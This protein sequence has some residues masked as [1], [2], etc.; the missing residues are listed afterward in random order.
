MKNYD[1]NIIEKKWQTIWTKQNAFKSKEKYN[2]KKYYCLVMLPY[3]SG[4]LHMG[5]V[6]NYTIGDVL[7]RFH[8]MNGENVLHPMGWD[9]FGLPAENAAIANN[10]HPEIW[11]KKNIS[12]MKKQLITLG[13]SYDWD[14]EITTCTPDYYKWNQWFFIQMFKMGLVFRK[15]AKV[16]WCQTCN[17]VLAN[18]QVINGKCWRCDKHTEYKNLKQWFIKIT[19]YAN[20]LIQYSNKL[21]GWPN[22]VISMQNHWIG[23][24]IGLEIN[25]ILTVAQYKLKIFTTR[26]DTI[27]GVTFIAISKEHNLLKELKHY[28]KNYNSILNYISK[29][30]IQT[31]NNDNNKY[32]ESSDGIMIE[33]IKAI[34]PINGN[35]LPIFI[36]EYVLMEYGTGAIM[37]VPA[38]DKRDWC[39]AKQYNVPIIEVIH[40]KKIAYN[41][42]KPYEG[43]GI[44][45][46]S[47]KFNGLT[48]SK[49]IESISQL[50]ENTGYGKKV[51]IFKL[52]DWLISRQRYW[53]T[54]IP[55]IYCD[56][57]GTMPV[58]IHDLPVILP[59]STKISTLRKNYS[60]INVKCPKCQRNAKRETDTMDTFVDS[61]WYYTRYCD[62]NN[63]KLAFSINKVNYW[64]PVNQ[65]IGG[66]EHACMHLVYARFWY[67]F[68]RDIGMIK[69]S[70]PFI[71]LLTQGMVTLNGKVMSKS[72]GNTVSPDKI[73]KQYGADSLRLFILFAAP[74]TKQ[75]DWTI[76]GLQGCR[77][78]IKR[79]WNLF[80]IVNRKSKFIAT[81]QDKRNLLQ[82]MHKTIK[83]V[84]ETMQ[85][86]F[87]FN[88][89]IANIMELV[90]SLYIYKY[91]LNDDKTS[92]TV[93]KTI[94]ILLYPFIPHVCEELLEMIG[95]KQNLSYYPWPS[96]N[97][98]ALNNSFIELP[99][100]INGKIRGT[101]KIPI[102][103]SIDLIKK[104]INSDNKISSLLKNKQI[105][106]FMY[107]KNRIVTMVIK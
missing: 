102:K 85:K 3:P 91:H 38:H 42:Q 98:N 72:K 78:F 63:N 30:K 7:A 24:S 100:Q 59:K 54:P 95:Y 25:F 84:T 47:Y 5:H 1:H 48:S 101:I 4:T 89:A 60:F 22:Q 93:Y 15:T 28:I 80:E 14:R 40:N 71:N 76:E 32:K 20:E 74:P 106:K 51:T 61:A 13:M 46:N 17:T 49:A 65:Y 64:M 88:T 23:K 44:L 31:I 55:I 8:R 66:I 41:Q 105:I 107:V 77:R 58:P 50:L 18:E 97:E 52:R 87:K 94:I 21:L 19:K 45:I 26:P 103:A 75:L 11:T 16:N 33:G 12:C 73:I 36:A 62:V 92:L 9:S 27:Y 43:D 83:K 53:G 70:E 35:E 57:C 39:F 37:A 81:V 69:T 34:N 10:I 86:G 6:R 90:N 56:I 2:E 79:L 82:L 68:M 67:K 99:V 104:Y 96:Y 29:N